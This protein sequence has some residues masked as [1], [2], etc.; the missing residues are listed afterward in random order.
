[1]PTLEERWIW[2]DLTLPLRAIY[3]PKAH[4]A[5]PKMADRCSYYALR[6]AER[7]L[8]AP[9]QYGMNVKDFRNRTTQET[10]WHFNA[11]RE[12]GW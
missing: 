6:M 11:N 7:E 12:R 5:S 8:S 4:H 1:M 9:L 2:L 10:K 3:I